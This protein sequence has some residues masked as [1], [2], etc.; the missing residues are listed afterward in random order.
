MDNILTSTPENFAASEFSISLAPREIALIIGQTRHIFD[1]ET[2]QPHKQIKDWHASYSLS[3]TSAKQL[4]M[5]LSRIIELYEE[6]FG[7]I[8]TDPNANEF[9]PKPLSK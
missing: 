4:N 7:Q 3:P 2:G 9:T 8:P 5:A 6:S 1:Q